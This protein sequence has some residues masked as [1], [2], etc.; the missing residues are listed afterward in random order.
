MID[1]GTKAG[2][3]ALER[4]QG[5]RIAWLTTVTPAGQPQ[6]LPIWFIWEDGTILFYGKKVAV[7]NANL[8][9]NPRVAFHLSD[10]GAGGDIVEI[11]GQAVLD[12]AAPSSKDHPAYLDKYAELLASYGWTPEYF[13]QEY[14]H[15]YRITPAVARY[16]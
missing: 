15:A 2:A 14:P 5:E 7:R 4:L 13:A 8:R 16:H 11:E 12:A 9:Q 3:H 1:A 10:D 6:T